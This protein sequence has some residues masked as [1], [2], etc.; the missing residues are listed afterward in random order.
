[1]E[2]IVELLKGI[3]PALIVFFTTLYILKSFFENETKKRL[4]DLKG[5]SKELITPIQLNAYERLV[6]FLERIS[7][8]Q[9]VIRLNKSHYSAKQ[10]HSELIST[11]RTEFE[12]NIAQQI[13]VSQKSWDELKKAKEETIKLLNIAYLKVNDQSTSLEYSNIIFE[14]AMSLKKLPSEI[15]IEILKKEIAQ[16]F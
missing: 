3:L 13:Y 7:P 8:Y 12:H 15:A 14:V 11:I 6:L 16:K 4:F 10:M 5:V 1:M 9:I 2:L